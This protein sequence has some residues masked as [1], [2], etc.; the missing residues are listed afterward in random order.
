MPWMAAHEL[1]NLFAKADT[2]RFAGVEID[3]S[4]GKANE[5]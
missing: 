5:K 1:D 4:P 3:H 2:Q